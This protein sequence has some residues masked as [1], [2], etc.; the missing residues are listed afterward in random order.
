MVLIRA[1][2]Y[3]NS[4]GIRSAGAKPSVMAGSYWQQLAHRP[5]QRGKGVRGPV[6]FRL[7]GRG[8]EGAWFGKE[9]GTGCRTLRRSRGSRVTNAGR[10][11]PDCRPT[12]NWLLTKTWT[13]TQFTGQPGSSRLDDTDH[14]RHLTPWG[15]LQSTRGV[16]L[17]SR[18]RFHGE[19][20]VDCQ[21]IPASRRGGEAAEIR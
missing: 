13:R 2:P 1:G 7:R 16:A 5:G 4:P 6:V 17:T 9:V 21:R 12:L 20:L 10:D 14:I 3:V 19:N 11:F 15:L 18:N 8:L